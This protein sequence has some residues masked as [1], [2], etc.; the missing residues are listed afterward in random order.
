[1]A[2]MDQKRAEEDRRRDE[3]E[4]RALK[5]DRLEQELE[6]AEWILEYERR[7]AALQKKTAAQRSRPDPSPSLSQIGAG[8]ADGCPDALALRQD[9]HPLPLWI[10]TIDKICYQE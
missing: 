5:K 7:L 4:A 3:Q 6:D 10:I 9:F 1:M 2:R 8:E